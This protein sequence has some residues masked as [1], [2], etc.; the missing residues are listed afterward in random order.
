MTILRSP[1]VAVVVVVVVFFLECE[2]SNR[3]YKIELTTRAVAGSKK[4]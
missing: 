1:A 3:P 4:Q 2:T